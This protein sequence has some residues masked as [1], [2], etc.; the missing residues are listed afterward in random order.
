ML[1][2]NCI[3]QWNPV[4]QSWSFQIY[5]PAR[6][7]EKR[8][9]EKH[10][11]PRAQAAARDNVRALLASLRATSDTAAI[12][13]NVQLSDGLLFLQHLRVRVSIISRSGKLNI[14]RILN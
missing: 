7:T 3:M 14:F 12:Q 2:R 11:R 10:R 13:A 1:R 5:L 4:N 8:Q 9:K 6:R